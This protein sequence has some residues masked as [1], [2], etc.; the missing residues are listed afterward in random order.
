MNQRWGAAAVNQTTKSSSPAVQINHRDTE[1]RSIL[2]IV[3]Y[4]DLF[5]SLRLLTPLCLCGLFAIPPLTRRRPLWACPRTTPPTA[6]APA[7]ETGATDSPV[8]LLRHQ[9][10]QLERCRSSWN[11]PRRPNS[12]TTARRTPGTCSDRFL[13]RGCGTDPPTAPILSASGSSPS[14]SIRAWAAGNPQ[15]RAH[16]PHRPCVFPSM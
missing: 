8:P 12:A 4:H 9:L 1:T 2:Q 16:L 7:P 10:F 3:E 14:A 5:F 11:P 6:P 15:L 13:Q